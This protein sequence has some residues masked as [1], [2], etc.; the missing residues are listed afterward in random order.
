MIK[1][2]YKYSE[3]TAK[4]LKSAFEVPL[5]YRAITSHGKEDNATRYN[6]AGASGNSSP[7][8]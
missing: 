7:M 5:C 1:E 8:L 2:Q 4:I 6:R 3:I